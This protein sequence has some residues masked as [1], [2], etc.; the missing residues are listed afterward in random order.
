MAKFKVGDII[1][2]SLFNGLTVKAIKDNGEYVLEDRTGATKDVYISLVD[3]YGVLVHEKKI[4]YLKDIEIKRN[5]YYVDKK[6]TIYLY[7]GKAYSYVFVDNKVQNAPDGYWTSDSYYIYVRLN[8]ILKTLKCKVEDLNG[9]TVANIFTKLIS[10]GK[11]Q[12]AYFS[13]TNPR[14]FIKEA[15]I[16]A[17][18]L[19]Y[20]DGVQS[21]CALNESKQIYEKEMFNFIGE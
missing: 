17:Q 10:E 3:K 21:F 13:N 8:Y 1:N 20:L 19:E 15:D 2:Y 18:G 5:H 16:P 12:K 7:L 4:K 11:N 9:L 14:K 6:N